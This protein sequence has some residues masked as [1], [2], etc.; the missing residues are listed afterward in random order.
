[1]ALT[2]GKM[3]GAV[4]QQGK[5]VRKGVVVFYLSLLTAKVNVEKGDLY[6]SQ[7]SARLRSLRCYRQRLT[8]CGSLSLT[9]ISQSETSHVPERCPKFG[10][11]A[12]K[13]DVKNERK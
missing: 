3:E 8:G 13:R 6:G 2:K 7:L 11:A 1:M 4:A 12:V 5:D 10:S 9:Q